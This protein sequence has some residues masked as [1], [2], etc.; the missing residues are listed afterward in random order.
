MRLT[1]YKLQLKISGI[2]VGWGIDILPDE[3]TKQTMR[4]HFR[5]AALEILDKLEERDID[6]G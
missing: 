6:R 4:M 2:L 3:F 5:T 1:L